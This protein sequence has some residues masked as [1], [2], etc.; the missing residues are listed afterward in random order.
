MKQLVGLLSVILLLAAC[1]RPIVETRH[2]TSL[3]LELAAIDT[4]MQTRPDSAMSLLLDAPMDNPYYQLLLSE[5]LYKNDSA[6]LNRPQLLEAMA[7]FDSVG[8]PFLSARCHYMNGVGYYEM[9]SVVPACEEYLKALEIMEEHFGEKELVGYKA[10]FMALTYTRLTDVF[11]DQYLHEQAIYFAKCIIPYF[12]R[13]NPE[14]GHVAWMLNEIGSHYDMMEQLDSAKYY[15]QRAEA[16][17]IDTF[18]ILY[19]DIETHLAYLTYETE[20]LALIPLSRLYHLLSQTESEKEF[21]SRCLIIGEIYYQEKNQDSA[22]FYLDKVY[23]S[24]KNI[25]VKIL[26]AQHLQE[27]CLLL[28]DTVS[29]NGFSHFLSQQA[30]AGD[31]QATL[32]SKLAELYHVFEQKK[33]ARIHLHQREK[34]KRWNNYLNVAILV[35]VVLMSVVAVFHKKRLEKECYTNKIQKSVIMGRLKR[36][37]EKIKELNKHIEIQQISDFKTSEVFAAS[38]EEEPICRFIL[39]QVKEGQFKS[40]IGYKVYKNYALEKDHLLALRKASDYHFNHFTSRL[41]KTYPSLHNSDINYCCLY[42]LG[43]SDADLA[44][45][46]QRAYNTINE[47]NNKLKRI[48][49]SETTLSVALRAFANGF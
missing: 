5:A 18:N 17:L 23:D 33:D 6:Q 35:I 15:Y 39:Q 42:L 24:S 37:N 36:S 8:C 38:F 12:N 32:H 43:L 27:I 10:K 16:V 11:S 4:L 25:S 9:D 14:P 22:R 26:S 44:A 3:P 20:K 41:I 31:V 40:N 30:N 48:M 2:G 34:T 1:H 49:D 45:L 28:G 7:Y 47:R 19:R 13:Y 46:M 21:L 29:M